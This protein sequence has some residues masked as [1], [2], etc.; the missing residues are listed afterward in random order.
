YEYAVWEAVVWEGVSVDTT[1]DGN[2]ATNT[3]EGEGVAYGHSEQFIGDGE[4]FEF[5]VTGSVSSTP[6]FSQVGVEDNVVN[7]DFFE[8][9]Q[10]QLSSGVVT[11][12]INDTY[13]TDVPY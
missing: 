4:F 10:F 9:Y 5:Q 13:E 3:T 8:Y 6:D 12:F 1:V 7:D 11:I 2:K